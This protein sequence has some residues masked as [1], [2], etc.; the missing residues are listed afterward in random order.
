VGLVG[1]GMSLALHRDIDFEA[2]RGY[3]PF[4]ELMRPKG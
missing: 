2:L 3:A 1:R 4:D